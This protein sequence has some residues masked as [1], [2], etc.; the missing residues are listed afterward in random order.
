DG[1]CKGEF[2][3]ILFYVLV[4][5]KKLNAQAFTALGL[6]RANEF[7]SFSADDQDYIRTRPRVIC[8]NRDC[9]LKSKQHR[10]LLTY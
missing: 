7:F 8:L 2:N 5:F 9:A 6:L 4:Q 1:T 3:S 10:L